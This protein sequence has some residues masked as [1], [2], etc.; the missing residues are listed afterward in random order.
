[1]YNVHST[2]SNTNVST[3]GLLVLSL[4]LPIFTFHSKTL[5][6]LLKN[7]TKDEKVIFVLSCI[8]I[9]HFI[10]KNLLPYVVHLAPNNDSYGCTFPYLVSFGEIFVIFQGNRSIIKYGSM[11]QRRL[12]MSLTI[13]AGDTCYQ[14]NG[15]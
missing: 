8:C 15:D 9:V 14:C 7:L 13:L 10:E 12:I 11:L 6:D 2:L 3:S 1:M 4:S 5:K